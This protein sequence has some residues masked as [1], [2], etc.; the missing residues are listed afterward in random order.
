M[1]TT[2]MDEDN[3]FD[4]SSLEKDTMLYERMLQGHHAAPSTFMH[5]KLPQ[6]YHQHSY[7]HHQQQQLPSHHSLSPAASQQFIGIDTYDDQQQS[8]LLHSNSPSAAQTARPSSAPFTRQDKVT[9]PQEFKLATEGIKNRTDDVRRE[10]E[11]R[12]QQECTFKPKISNYQFST[13][14]KKP[15]SKEARLRELAD[16]KQREYERRERERKQREEEELAQ[17]SFKPNVKKQ[18][19]KKQSDAVTERLFH[20]ADDKRI[21]R[22]KM[23]REQEM[24]QME[25]FTFRPQTNA[26]SHVDQQSYR[27]V[28]ERVGEMQRK[29]HEEMAR[30]K[31][32]NETE[33]ADLTFSPKINKKSQAIAMIK[34]NNATFQERISAQLSQAIEKKYKNQ[35]ENQFSNYTFKPEVN[36]NSEKMLKHS[37]M[38]NGEM[39]NFVKRQEFL[40]QQIK[41]QQ[42]LNTTMDE[43]EFKPQISETSKM[44][45]EA[46]MSRAGETEHDKIERLAFRDKQK[47]EALKEY[48]KEQY[49]KKYS[50][51][52]SIN[53]LSKVMAKA[54]DA[55]ELVHNER[56]KKIRMCYE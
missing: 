38:F 34:T 41:V 25:S 33:N 51:Q 15:Q 35:T 49:Y 45:V 47:S 11:Q 56:S 27:P 21:K 52:P 29:K 22:E 42:M 46:K 28:H 9:V 20:E 16:S 53:E 10:V 44:I 12:I 23:K 50:F 48:V 13:K 26:N 3:E 32:K 14:N 39:A 31:I 18:A 1:P 30:L 8:P 36:P 24:Q 54:T 43:Y 2:R 55:E 19:S 40:Q 7:P 5:H 37:K 17:L 4:V 6:Q